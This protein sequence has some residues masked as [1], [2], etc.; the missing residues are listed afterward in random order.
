[1]ILASPLLLSTLL[2]GVEALQAEALP[3]VQPP[4]GPE[5]P[6]SIGEPPPPRDPKTISPR[7]DKPL[8]LTFLVDGLFYMEGAHLWMLPFPAA[9]LTWAPY[10]R[11]AFDLQ[12]SHG[13]KA[14]FLTGGLRGYLADNV[15][16]PYI[17]LRTTIE[18]R[19]DFCPS[20][21]CSKD[22]ASTPALQ[23]GLGTDFL[24]WGPFFII[25]EF[26]VFLAPHAWEWAF[27]LNVGVGAR[28]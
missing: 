28:F 26:D 5:D 11:I 1:M 10:T 15:A 27:R 9:R 2:L 24:L 7:E 20:G 17:D 8:A 12:L 4:A 16:A 25:E 3:P 19:G 13:E 22:R 21:G 18:T 6:L 23:A 14:Q